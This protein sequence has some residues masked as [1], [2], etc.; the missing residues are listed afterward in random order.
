MIRKGSQVAYK[1]FVNGVKQAGLGK[2]ISIDKE[3]Q[4][5][6]V[7]DYYNFYTC[8]LKDCENVCNW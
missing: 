8:L 1:C 4:T 3:N 2:V 7:A 5:C 6:I